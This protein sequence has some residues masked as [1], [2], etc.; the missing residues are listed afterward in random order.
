MSEQPWETTGGSTG[1]REREK[2][3]ERERERAQ[4][5][6]LCLS[7]KGPGG[8]GPQGAAETGQEQIN[9]ALREMGCTDG[10]IARAPEP[11]GPVTAVPTL[12]VC[13][14][15]HFFLYEMRITVTAQ[16]LSPRAFM[17]TK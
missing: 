3:R 5:R 16:S 9:S 13:K 4:A 14:G 2:E 1:Q 8:K 15:L 17:T 11:G 12:A 7:W 10:A 6:T